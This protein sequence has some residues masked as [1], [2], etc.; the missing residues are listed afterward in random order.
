MRKVIIKKN[1]GTDLI[2][3][4]EIGN[5]IKSPFTTMSIRTPMAETNQ[6]S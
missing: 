1:D 2:N 5:P 6:S 3:S 4:Y